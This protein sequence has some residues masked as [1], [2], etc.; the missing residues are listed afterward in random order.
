MQTHDIRQFDVQ[1]VWRKV[2]STLWNKKY[3][4]WKEERLVYEKLTSIF[5][6]KEEEKH[7]DV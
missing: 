5:V 2:F 4:V 1:A 7:N 3:C 6:N